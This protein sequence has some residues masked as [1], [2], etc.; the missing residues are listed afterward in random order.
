[1]A[2]SAWAAYKWPHGA[3]DPLR[4]HHESVGRGWREQTASQQNPRALSAF[5]NWRG[6]GLMLNTGAP[7]EASE[8][9]S[10]EFTEFAA[11]A[12]AVSYTHLTLPT[13]CSV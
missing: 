10:P 1:M 4:Q 7:I 8:A 13:I 5:E 6:M 2:Y 9:G 11:G 3:A 12:E